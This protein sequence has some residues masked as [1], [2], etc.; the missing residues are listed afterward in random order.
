M[1]NSSYRSVDEGEEDEGKREVGQEEQKQGEGKDR[2]EEEDN[3]DNDD[4]KEEE[5]EGKVI[6]EEHRE[7]SSTIGNATQRI[8]RGIRDKSNHIF[9]GIDKACEQFY[10]MVHAAS[11]GAWSSITFQFSKIYIEYSHFILS[12][13]PPAAT[14]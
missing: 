10:I 14:V 11:D 4:K 6:K 3:E 8:S 7:A 13:T 5:E 12:F 9:G 2:E 1:D